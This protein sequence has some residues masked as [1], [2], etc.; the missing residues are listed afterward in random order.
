MLLKEKETKGKTGYDTTLFEQIL[1]IP[2]QSKKEQKMVQFIC[3]QLKKLNISYE[4][5]E[6][7]IIATKKDKDYTGYLSGI[8]CHIDT[9]HDITGIKKVQVQKVEKKEKTF[10]F[11]KQGIGGDDKCGIF[12]CLEL[13]KNN[14]NIK[15]YFFSNEEIGMVG[16]SNLDLEEF[17]DLKFLIEIDRKGTSDIIS[18]H[19]GEDLI[20]KS[21]KKLIE[22]IMK[23]YNMKHQEGIG[24]DVSTLAEHGLNLS[25]INVSAGYYNAHTLKEFICKEHLFR[26]IGVIQE[27][28]DTARNIKYKHKFISTWDSYKGSYQTTTTKYNGYQECIICGY[29][30]NI[31]YESDHGF[32]CGQ[33]MEYIINSFFNNN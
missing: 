10:Y 3:K 21:F 31:G 19:Q 7:N 18:I 6:N 30:D 14:T 26:N 5:K 17:D 16:S 1:A 23:K 2:S 15:A 27:I 4:T 20:S 12:A 32:I 24:T 9:V 8:C 28:I 29:E 33:C 11:S 25:V 13:L 22:P